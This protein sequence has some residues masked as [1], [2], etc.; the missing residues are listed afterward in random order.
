MVFDYLT[1]SFKGNMEARYQMHDAQCLAGMAF[2]NAL[3]GIV[4]SCHTK[5]VLHSQQDILHMV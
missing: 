1:A 4:H 5:L 2:S 3:L